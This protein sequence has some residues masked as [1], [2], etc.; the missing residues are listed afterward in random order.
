M[1]KYLLVASLYLKDYAGDVEQFKRAIRMCK[2]RSHGVMLFDVVY[3]EDYN[4]WEEL[5]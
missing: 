1:D 2:E 5:A 3:L 4:W